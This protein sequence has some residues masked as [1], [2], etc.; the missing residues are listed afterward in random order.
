MANVKVFAGPSDL[1]LAVAEEFLQL[2]AT[3]IA[4]QGRFVV[5]LAGGST[6]RAAY[7]LLASEPYA[8]RVDWPR[9][10]FLW[11]DERCVPPDHSESNYRMAREAFLDHVP[12][13]GQNVYRV[14]GEMEPVQAADTYEDT[15]R[16]LFG[17]PIPRIDLVMLGMGTDGHTASLFPGTAAIHETKR[18]VMAHHVEKLDAWRVTLTPVVLNGASNVLFVVSG[19]DKAKRLR[20]VLEGPLQ[21]DVLP[22][23]I[24]EPSA[25]RLVWMVDEAGA[26]EL[27]GR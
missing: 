4:D 17:G 11:G 13:P 7:T 9:V 23:Q 18:W 24:V 20:E 3:A 8:S 27:S 1:A 5:A 16:A 22:A 25:G 14:L 19:G 21:P 6:P 2:T 12:V 26:A 15:L 10:L